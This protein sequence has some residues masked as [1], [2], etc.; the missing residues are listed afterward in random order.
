M[1]HGR[2]NSKTTI[3][4]NYI[5]ISIHNHA[6]LLHSSGNCQLLCTDLVPI[7]P[8]KFWKNYLDPSKPWRSP[9]NLVM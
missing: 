3:K 1:V 7:N 6:I 4:L 5:K 2:D 9:G 8:V